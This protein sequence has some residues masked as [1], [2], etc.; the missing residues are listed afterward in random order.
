MD[1]RMSTSTSLDL[2]QA[3][4]IPAFEVSIAVFELP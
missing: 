1:E 4:Q 2:A 3:N